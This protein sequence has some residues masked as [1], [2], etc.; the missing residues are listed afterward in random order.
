MQN[1]SLCPN[2]KGLIKD[3]KVCPHCGYVLDKSLSR[4]EKTVKHQ[5]KTPNLKTKN[6]VDGADFSDIVD[7]A[8]LNKTIIDATKENSIEEA[9]SLGQTADHNEDT[10]NKTLKKPTDQIDI[11]EQVNSEK[12]PEKN[13]Q[14]KPEE[15]SEK[16][17]GTGTDQHSGAAKGMKNVENDAIKR[18]KE[19]AESYDK[20]VKDQAQDE[21]KTE[22]KDQGKTES[23]FQNKSKDQDK[24]KPRLQSRSK[25]QGKPD[26]KTQDQ[27]AD[28]NNKQSKSE[29]GQQN[30]KDEKPTNENKKTTTQQVTSLFEELIPDNF[31]PKVEHH[32]TKAKKLTPIVLALVLFI[33][34]AFAYYKFYYITPDYVIPMVLSAEDRQAIEAQQT[35]SGPQIPITTLNSS[36]KTLDLKLPLNEGNFEKGNLLAFA[37]DNLKMSLQMFDLRNLFN[38]YVK[39]DLLDNLQKDYTFTDDDLKVYLSDGYALLFPN[40]DLKTWGYVAEIKD[41]DFVKKRADQFNKD[42]DKEDFKYKDYYVEIVEVSENKAKGLEDVDFEQLQKELNGQAD[43]KG[44]D[45]SNSADTTA[46]DK[47]QENNEQKE[48]NTED[49]NTDNDTDTNNM[50]ENKTDSDKNATN[51]AKE[52]EKAENSKRYYLIFSNSKEFL[53]Q[54]KESTEGNLPNLSDNILYVN[55]KE[56]LPIIGQVFVFKQAT[57]TYKALIN[58]VAPQIKYE[59]LDKILQSIQ[60]K[61]FVVLQKGEKTKII[62]SKE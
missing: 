62:Q 7:P 3:E 56:E 11:K 53:D 5:E 58:Y 42:R 19:K 36:E 28:D 43:E 21:T 1:Q 8:I 32:A 23:E 40:N 10:H 51:S 49:Q 12:Q 34:A 31:Q 9:L 59:G 18:Q 45:E 26:P 57:D 16:G 24:M 2:C 54:M 47:N 22:S 14:T 55:A 27:S 39:S 4:Q 50:A 17:G 48:S 6:V 29:V 46:K 44:T 15:H 33:I 41:I 13:R 37:P 38:T 60:S 52:E 25:D 30:K 35:S 61:D 20:K